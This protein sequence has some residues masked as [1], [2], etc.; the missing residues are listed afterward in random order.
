MNDVEN[1]NRRVLNHTGASF[2]KR[3]GSIESGIAILTILGM[4]F[5]HVFIAHEIG[6]VPAQT[7]R[8]NRLI[9][10]RKQVNLSL[11]N[12]AL[13]HFNSLQS[14]LLS[15][16][17]PQSS[18][19]ASSSSTISSAMSTSSFSS[20][21][22]TNTTSFDPTK[23]IIFQS[24]TLPG[25]TTKQEQQLEEL[26]KLRESME[27]VTPERCIQI[28][29]VVPGINPRNFGEMVYERMTMYSD[30]EFHPSNPSNPSNPSSM[31]STSS[32]IM[33][34]ED[35]SADMAIIR[36]IA[37]RKQKQSEENRQFRTKAKR[38]LETLEK[39]R[40]FKRTTI[41]VYLPDRTVIQA[42]FAPRETIGDVMDVV[43][44]AF[45][46]QY[47]SLPFYL[48]NAPP[49]EVLT[50]STQLRAIR[51]VPVAMVYLG[52]ENEGPIVPFPAYAMNEYLS[53]AP[54]ADQTDRGALY[55]EREEEEEKE[56][57][58]ERKKKKK[59]AAFLSAMRL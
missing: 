17:R 39:Q 33:D 38:E 44:S 47:R 55:A 53:D 36:E 19:S 7:D 56:R 25:V 8:G 5:I 21:T 52:W 23:P 41:R 6:F 34:L 42:Y 14:I 58:K 1:D 31:T 37:A 15:A 12:Q 13:A 54:I 59:M 49:K 48:F 30:K 18:Y 2:Q 29:Q 24:M 16:S 28:F 10:P 20:T 57:E 26:Q 9:L 4:S 11:L 27:T 43:R 46:P 22:S 45:A 3:I 40:A 50:P 51:M 32:E 35:E